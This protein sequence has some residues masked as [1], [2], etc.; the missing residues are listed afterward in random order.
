MMLISFTRAWKFAFQNFTRNLWLSLVTVLILSLTL[1]SI[2]LSAGL[3]VVAKQSLAAVK[4]R[5]AVS[6]YFI[7]TAVAEDVQNVQKAVAALPEVKDVRY[8]SPEDALADFQERT[9]DNP[10]I[11]DTL[12]ALGDNPLGATLVIKTRNI[13]DYP[14][15][16]S[17]LDTPDYAKLIQ[18]KD[19]DENQL[20]VTRLSSLAN[21]IQNV[22]F[23]VSGLFILIAILV[24]FNSIRVTIHSYRDEIGIMKLVGATN[25][26]VRSPFIYESMMYAVVASIVTLVAS[27]VL[28]S[29]SGPF[30]DQFFTGYDFHLTSYFSAHL[31]IIVGLELGV[32][33]VLAMASTAFAVGRYLRV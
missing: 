33:L 17:V 11:A 4:D 21:R 18:D 24:T 12:S 20:L 27:G 14:K 25:W 15:V 31:L 2:T 10:L 22:G 3:T 16:Q 13:E 32:S 7:P 30:F 29:V 19:F 8:V 1:F 9:K 23:A 5:V 28:V 6:V 26:F